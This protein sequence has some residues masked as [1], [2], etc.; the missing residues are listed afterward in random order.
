MQDPIPNV[1]FS[2]CK[3]IK[4]N[5]QYIDSNEFNNKLA[6]PLKE[7]LNEEDIDVKYYSEK[8]LTS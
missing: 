2:A 1:R 7:N 5:R 3:Q 8:A 6:G 4:Q